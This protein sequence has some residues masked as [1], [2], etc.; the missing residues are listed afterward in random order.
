VS[1]ILPVYVV[2]MQPVEPIQ[3]IE[4]TVSGRRQQPWIPLSWWADRTD[5]DQTMV[6][7]ATGEP[8]LYGPYGSRRLR[9]REVTEP[10]CSC[11]PP[12]ADAAC[13][14]HGVKAF[15]SQLLGGEVTSQ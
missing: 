14:D 7:Y 12:F 10:P 1:A 2:E 4:E 5:A 6:V 13:P 15:L 9:V 3:E 8:H 11:V